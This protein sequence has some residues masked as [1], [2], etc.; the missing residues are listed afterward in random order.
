MVLKVFKM[1]RDFCHFFVQLFLNEAA[2][3]ARIS[4]MK[5][6]IKGFSQVLNFSYCMIVSLTVLTIVMWHTVTVKVCLWHLSG[7]NSTKI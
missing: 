3:A 4:I 5:L 6:I 1:Q 2:N 7:A